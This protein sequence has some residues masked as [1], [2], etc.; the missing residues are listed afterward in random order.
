MANKNM[1]Y[2]HIG[3][4]LSKF[5]KTAEQEK[6]E[7]QEKEVKKRRQ[8]RSK[9]SAQKRVKDFLYS[10]NMLID[11]AVEAEQT[12]TREIEDAKDGSKKEMLLQE[13]LDYFVD[14]QID[15]DKLKMIL[16]PFYI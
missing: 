5:S 7:E 3:P 2:G 13:T 10:L 11:S 15:L 6:E 16:N 14:F 4:A 8:K 1:K 12:L 9:V